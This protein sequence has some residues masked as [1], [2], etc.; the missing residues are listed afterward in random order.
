M[1]HTEATQI[2]KACIKNGVRVCVDCKEE[3]S[4]GAYIVNLGDYFPIKGMGWVIYQCRK[5]YNKN[6][7]T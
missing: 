7:G 5:C 3:V 4:I 2:N 1:V 6:N